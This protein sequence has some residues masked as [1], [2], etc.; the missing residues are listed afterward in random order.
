M[1]PNLSRF[2]GLFR[3]RDADD[4]T[5]VAKVSATGDLSV[6]EDARRRGLSVFHIAAGATV[7]LQ[8]VEGQIGDYLDGLYLKFA[9][10]SPGTVTVIDGDGLDDEVS[11]VVWD[12]ITLPNRIPR[13]V[14]F[15]FNS[16][17][18]AITVA[19]GANVEAF[20]FCRPS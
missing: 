2:L 3:L 11:Y 10:T 4:S 15:P 12:A 17:V 13:A 5:R 6:I 18:G 8:N 7:V 19:C 14:Y 16:K 9:S 1:G 20:A